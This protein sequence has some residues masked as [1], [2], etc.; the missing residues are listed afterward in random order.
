MEEMCEACGNKFKVAT[1]KES[2]SKVYDTIFSTTYDGTT[3]KKRIGECTF[4]RKIK[5][6]ILRVASLFS[7]FAR[8]D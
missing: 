5:D 1:I 4:N 7:T 8:L 6:T 3:Y 2:L